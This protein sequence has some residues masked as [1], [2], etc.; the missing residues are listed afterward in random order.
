[1]QHGAAPACCWQRSWS[2]FADLPV[3][4]T[5]SFQQLLLSKNSLHELQVAAD[6]GDKIK[7]LKID[8]DQNPELSTQLQVSQLNAVRSGWRPGMC[9]QTSLLLVQYTTLQLSN[10][11]LHAVQENTLSATQLEIVLQIQGLPTM[12]FIGMDP[13]KPALRTEGLLPAATIKQ[14]VQ[15][16]LSPAAAA[17]TPASSQ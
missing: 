9:V 17:P 6:L 5:A 7:V 4:H 3:T 14:I 8:T 1:M 11:L 15:D 2:R 13:S 16:E 10:S 12:V